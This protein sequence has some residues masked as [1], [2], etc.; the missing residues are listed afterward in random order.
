M[1]HYE[2]QG[3]ALAVSVMV[4]AAGHGAGEIA[5]PIDVIIEVKVAF[6]H[7]AL[8]NAGMFVERRVGALRT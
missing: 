4:H 8:L 3:P 7:Q 6:Q 2:Q 5:R 1:R